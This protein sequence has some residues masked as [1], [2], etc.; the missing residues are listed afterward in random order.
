MDENEAK[1][2][3]FGITFPKCGLEKNNMATLTPPH[4]IFGGAP[5]QNPP[6]R[7]GENY[8]PGGKENFFSTCLVNY[9]FFSSLSE[10]H[11]VGFDAFSFEWTVSCGERCQKRK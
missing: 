8:P 11:I 10:A 6:G 2:R 7:G 3:H 4:I 9:A 5:L 1:I